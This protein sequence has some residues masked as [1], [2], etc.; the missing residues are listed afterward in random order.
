[1]S[2]A[3]NGGGKILNFSAGAETHQNHLMTDFHTLLKIQLKTLK[4]LYYNKKY[5]I[6]VSVMKMNCIEKDTACCFTGHRIIKNCDRLC[7]S[8]NLAYAVKNLYSSGM[9]SFISGGAIGFDTEAALAVINARREM[10]DIRLIMALPCP[11]QDKFWTAEQKVV[12]RQILEDADEIIY[13]SDEYDSGC[14][15][16]RNR[17]MVDNSSLVLA[18]IIHMS[19]GTAYTVKYA[20]K[21]DCEVINILNYIQR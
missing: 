8:K 14:M 1:M 5:V 13:V 15:H 19:S 17:F 18:Y 4:H 20:L 10:P 3:S 9:R 21:N 6:I 16:R 7:V 11:E 2:P 12:Y